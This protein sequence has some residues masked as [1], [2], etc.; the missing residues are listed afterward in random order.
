MKV[1]TEV[2]W[3]WSYLHRSKY[4]D[5]GWSIHHIARH[6]SYENIGES[7]YWK[8]SD[9]QKFLCETRVEIEIPDFDGIKL[10]EEILES[11][12]KEITAK[13]AAEKAFI[14]KALS[15]LR[16]ITYTESA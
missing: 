6:D 1:E 8:L 11:Q 7:E 2:V 12:L 13:F 14:E 16:A 3:I 15:E 10:Q 4:S 9:K 5:S